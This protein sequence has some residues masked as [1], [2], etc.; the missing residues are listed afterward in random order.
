MQNYS[1]IVTRIYG[2]DIVKSS[3]EHNTG[4]LRETHYYTVDSQF[5]LSYLSKA[6]KY[7]EHTKHMPHL[8]LY[9]L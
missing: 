9:P 8:N 1:F 3:N 7:F 6:E 4:V 2:N 5:L